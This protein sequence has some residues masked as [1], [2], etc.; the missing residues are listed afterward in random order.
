MLLTT[1]TLPDIPSIDAGGASYQISEYTSSLT[2][3]GPASAIVCNVPAS[4]TL[5]SGFD[6]ELTMMSFVFGVTFFSS[7]SMSMR[8]SGVLGARASRPPFFAKSCSTAGGTPA[9]PGSRSYVTG[10][11]PAMRASVA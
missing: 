2:T 10:V 1:M 6:G 8:H 4:I 3:S 11:A 7:A 5:P 9:L